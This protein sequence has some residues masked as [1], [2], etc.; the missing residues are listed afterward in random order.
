MTE[1]ELRALLPQHKCDC[2]RA[3]VIIALGYPPIAPVLQDLLEWLK[4]CNWPVSHSI[5]P[6][7]ASIGEPLLPL[8]H[9]VL[10]GN[11]DTWKYWCIDRLIM[12]FPREL[13]GQFRS[14]LQR[15]AFQP[16]SQQRSEELDERARAA[17]EWLDGRRRA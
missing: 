9:E 3:R 11:D 10:R 16:T 17:L 4:D 5:A 12:G 15:F 13:A 14:E 8:I 2:E 7:L 1:V 6:F